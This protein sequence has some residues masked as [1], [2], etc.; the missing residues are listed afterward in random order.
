MRRGTKLFICLLTALACVFTYS[1]A[2]AQSNGLG[3]SPRKDYTVKAGE[4]AKDTIYVSNLSKDE[5]L[6]LT[7]RVVD[8]RAQDETGS[9]ALEQRQNVEPTAWSARPF[10]TVPTTLT[11]QP[12]KSTQVPISVS[13]PANQGAGS[14]YSAIEY[15]AENSAGNKVS[16]AASSATLVFIKVPGETKELLRLEQ[17]GTYQSESD[18]SKGS[19]KSLFSAQLPKEL[20]YRLKNEGNIAEQPSGSI[21]IKN[22]FG[23]RVLV[24]DEANPKKSL[25]LLGQTRKFQTCI[26]TEKQ[27]VKAQ[28]GDEIEVDVCKSPNLKPGRYTAELTLL[29]GENGNNT[30]EI[31]AKAVFWYLPV[32]FVIALVLAVVALVAG[33]YLM[34][35]KVTRSKRKRR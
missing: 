16:V 35:R 11:I 23:K 10:L 17:F 30:R 8:F 13:I 2:N 7:I 1:H 6:N 9:P 25:A 20:A 19:F 34:Y 26:T 4:S 14:Y 27:K 15:E 3:I 29:Y 24:V 33:G 31:T 28:V 12:G 32:W 22:I 5:P 21:V 18:E